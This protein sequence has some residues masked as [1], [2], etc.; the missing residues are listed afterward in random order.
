MTGIHTCWARRSMVSMSRRWASRRMER[1]SS[2]MRWP[3][4]AASRLRASTETRRSSAS[5]SA[6]S[7]HSTRAALLAQALAHAPAHP[8]QVGGARPRPAPGQPVEGAAERVA[9]AEQHAELLGDDRQLGEDRSLPAGRRP[10]DLLLEHQ[11]GEDR[12][13]EQEQ[14]RPAAAVGARPPRSPRPGPARP[15]RSRAGAAGSWPGSNGAWMRSRRTASSSLTPNSRLSR[16]P[17]L[18]ASGATTSRNDPTDSTPTEPGRVRV[19]A[20]QVGSDAVD[21][22]PPAGTTQLGQHQH[23]A[24]RGQ[25]GHQHAPAGSPQHPALVGQAH[26]LAGPHPADHDQAEGHDHDDL[27]ERGLVG[28][29]TR[30]RPTAPPRPCRWGRSARTG[31][32]SARRPAW[33]GRPCGPGCR[34]GGR[35]PGRRGGGRG[36]CRPARGR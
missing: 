5:T 21:P 23:G 33:P 27:A 20:G 28:G 34:P 1:A 16:S 11:E 22:A 13:P 4:S 12:R 9:G 26:D 7:A 10:G 29:P 36:R 30:S 8:A 3:R 15:A 25:A 31:G 24:D 18:R 32:R 2:V 17:P 19:A 6:S 14:Q 35:R